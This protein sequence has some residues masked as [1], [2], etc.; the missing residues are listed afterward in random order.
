MEHLK[1]DGRETQIRVVV[2]TLL[3]VV[4]AEYW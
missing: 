3:G 4:A 2:E 1:H